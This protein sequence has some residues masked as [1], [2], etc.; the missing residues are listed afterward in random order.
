TADPLLLHRPKRPAELPEDFYRQINQIH[1]PRSLLRPDRFPLR[2]SSQ[3]RRSYFEENPLWILLPSPAPKPIRIQQA[4]PD[5]DRTP[6]LFE[7]LQ[8]NNSYP[9]YPVIFSPPSP[10][11]S[12]DCLFQ[13]NNT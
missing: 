8:R 11:L 7:V 4:E 13:N 6:I 1:F 3:K 12:T 10:L 9:W 5:P 2:L